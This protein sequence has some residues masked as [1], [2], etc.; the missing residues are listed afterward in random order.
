M[1][2]ACA[3]GKI[4]LLGEHAVVYG[5]PALAVPLRQVRAC[6]QITPAGDG[7]AGGLRLEAPALGLSMWHHQVPPGNPLATAV[8]AGLEALSPGL[9]GPL[10]LEIESTI[11]MASG[12][13]SSAAVS[14]AILRALDQHFG[15]DL[16][17]LQISDLAY[18]VE[19]IQHGTPS[20]IDNTVVSFD[21]PV[22]FVRGRPPEPLRIGASFHLVVAD[23][24]VAAPTGV[25]VGEVRRR[26]QTD[27]ELDRVFDSIGSLV[28]QARGAIEVGDSKLLGTCMNRN[29]ELLQRLGVSSPDLDRLVRA[30]I[31]A[32][33]LGAKM[34]GGGM[35]GN[36]VALTRA[37]DGDGV[38]RAL[39]GAGATGRIQSEVEP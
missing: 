30:A 7:P 2:R 16:S 39:Q 4:I 35:G 27:P 6:V 14:V 26:R 33:A 38:D 1:T 19:V 17:D 20:G 22:V 32:G 37:E 10:R 18:Q 8:R 36:M 31:D 21:R 12:L 24:G 5:R 13:G 3:P 29:H 25:A 34:S 11:P 9:F 15:G 23:T 28:D